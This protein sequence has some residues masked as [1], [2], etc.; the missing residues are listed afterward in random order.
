MEQNTES[1]LFELHV[2]HNVS[3]YLAET[4]RWAKFMAILGFVGCGF[5][6][7]FSLFIGSFLSAALLRM[8]GGGTAGLGYMGGFLSFIYI[9]IAIVYFFPCLYLYNFAS[10]M[11]V[12]LRSNDQ[13]QLSLS[14][15]NLRSCYRFV[16][17][18]MIIVLAFWALGAA[19]ALIGLAF[20][21]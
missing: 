3:A 6:L 11:Q 8:G 13:D 7:L 14:F 4:A 9:V 10:K 2:D 16:G 1:N 20:G 18:L 21:H 19:L 12:A 15:R 5:M 17:I